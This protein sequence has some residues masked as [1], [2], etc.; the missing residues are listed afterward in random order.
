MRTSSKHCILLPPPATK[1]P[2]DGLGRD[3]WPWLRAE[4]SEDDVF[5]PWGLR[6]AEGWGLLSAETDGADVTRTLDR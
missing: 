1:Y 3:N 5:L 2:E 6:N 4:G